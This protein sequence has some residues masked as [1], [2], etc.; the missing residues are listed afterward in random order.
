[1]YRA[2]DQHGQVID[3]YV[4]QRRVIASARTF[5]TAAFTAALTVHGVPTE[6]VTDRAPA[7]AI[8][9]EDLVPA[10][11]HNTGQYENHRVECDH[12]R[13][14]ARLR[15]MR[16]RKTERTASVVVRGHALVQNLRRGHNELGVDAYQSSGWTPHSTNSGPRSDQPV[17]GPYLGLAC[18]Q[19]MQ[20]CPVPTPSTT[21]PSPQSYS[22]HIPA[23]IPRQNRGPRLTTSR[24]GDDGRVVE[25]FR[26]DD[27]DD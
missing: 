17:P 27:Q 9:I 6:V 20:Q 24:V 8:V 26:F 23:H 19:T 3:V 16:G 4:S 25:M 11:L 21:E 7:L 10:G 5:F 12:G 1:V 18:D 13:L 15:P 22:S 2:V 14:R